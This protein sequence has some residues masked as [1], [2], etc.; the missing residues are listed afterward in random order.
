VV[1]RDL[2]R[3][4]PRDAAVIA[5][6]LKAAHERRGFFRP[7]ADARQAQRGGWKSFLAAVRRLEAARQGGHGSA[8]I[9]PREEICPHHILRLVNS[10]SIA[11]H[12]SIVLPALIQFLRLYRSRGGNLN[13]RATVGYCFPVRELNGAE[14]RA[15]DLGLGEEADQGAVDAV[16]AAQVDDDDDD[17]DAEEGRRGVAD[18]DAELPLPVEVPRRAPAHGVEGFSHRDFCDLV[19]ASD[20]T[21][22]DLLRWFQIVEDVLA[23]PRAGS[24]H[25]VDCFSRLA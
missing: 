5:R 12:G 22:N 14:D 24:N 6:A 10:L 7:M 23:T 15:L 17:G 25:A 20:L 9:V 19:R 1:M 16:A 11:K 13:L 8:V 21:V 2:P 4:P 18:A 3:L